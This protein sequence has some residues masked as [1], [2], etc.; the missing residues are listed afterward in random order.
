LK[1][2]WKSVLT[3]VAMLA[4]A[5]P[6]FA[7]DYPLPKK[8]GESFSICTGCKSLNSASEPN[9]G[10]PTWQFD[11]PL[12]AFAGRVV[13]SQGTQNIQHQGHR[14]LRAGLVRTAYTA[15]GSAPPRVYAYIGLGTFGA[16]TL[17]TFATTLKNPMTTVVTVNGGGVGLRNGKPEKVAKPD[18]MVYPEAP[19]SG[20]QVPFVD[21]T[22]RLKDFDFDD[23]GYVY[24]A[25][26]IFGWGIVKDSGETGIATLPLV[27][28]SQQV[29]DM[30]PDRIISIKSNNK[31]YVATSWSSKS[32]LGRRIYDVTDPKAPD[33]VSQTSGT[34]AQP[35]V[36]KQWSKDDNA[37]VVAVI[38]GDEVLR[39]YDY[40]AYVRNSAPM[41][42]FEGDNDY[43]SLSFDDKGVLW[44]I[45]AAGNPN[46]PTKVHKFTPSNNG[47]SEAILTPFPEWFDPVKIHARNGYLAAVGR[48]K[49]GP[50][51]RIN[52]FVF[53]TDGNGLTHLDTGDFFLKYYHAAPSGFAQPEGYT[54][55]PQDIHILKMGTK[56]Y[57]MYMVYGLGDVFQLEGSGP[58]LSTAIRGTTFGTPNPNSKGTAAGPFPGDPVTF[59]TTIS[60]ATGTLHNI[61]WNFGNPED[62]A[63]N[64]KSGGTGVDI[65]H[66]FTGLSTLAK[67]TTPKTVTA[68]LASDSSV[69]DATT[70]S[71]AVPTPR[72]AL[73]ATDE[74]LTEAGFAV[75]PNDKFVDASDGSIEGHFASW[76]I[77]N[78]TTK[79]RPDQSIPVGTLGDHT[80]ELTASYG[81]YDEDNFSTTGSPF[82]VKV[83]SL[84]YDVLPFLARFKP[85]S[86][87]GSTVTY[88]ATGRAT[89]D[90]AILTA[91]EWTFKWTLTSKSGTEKETLTGTANIPSIPNFSFDKSDLANEDVVK[92]ELNVLPAGLPGADQF[93]TFAIQ[94]EVAL[95][96]P[97][98]ELT[99][100]GFVND[101]CSIKAVSQ[102]GK[103]TAGWNLSWSVKQGT[104]NVKSGSGNPLETF[105]LSIEGTHTVSVT[106]TVFDTTPVTKNFTVE[107]SQCGPPPNVAQ[108]AIDHNCNNC[109]PGDEITLRA[110][111][112]HY[113][114][115]ECDQFLWNFDD[116]TT[117]SGATVKHTFTSNKTYNVKLTI[118]NPTNTTGITISEQVKVGSGSPPPPPPPTC[119]APANID[120]SWSGSGCSSGGSACKAGQNITFQGRRGT[121]SLQNCDSAAWTFDGA[122]SN[123]KTPTR[124]FTAGNHTVTLKVT[125]EKGSSDTVTKTVVI[126]PNTGGGNCSGSATI[127][128]VS[129]GFRGQTSGCTRTNG[130]ICQ[131]NETIDFTT[132]FFN[133]TQQACDR[134][135]FTFDDGTNALGGSNAAIART[136]TGTK[137][138][139]NVSV[140]VYNSTNTNGVTVS[141]LVPFSN[142]PV[143]LP[144]VLT[145]DFPTDGVKGVPMTFTV[146]ADRQATGWRWEFDG[147]P[148][149]S[150]QNEVGLSSTITHTFTTAGRKSVR[151]FAR[152]AAD[153]SGNAPTSNKLV[154]VDIEEP[155]EARYLLP[156]VGHAPGL[157]GSNWRTDVQFF[158]PIIGPNNP[159]VM[160]ATFNGTTKELRVADSTFIYS[161]FMTFFTSD[162]AIGPVI[163]SA[164]ADKA[165]QIWTRTY[166]QSE[167][168]TF[169]QF[170][171]AIRLDEA[172]GGAAV[173]SGMYYL[174]G[175]RH[176][177]RYR[178]NI[179]FVN[180]NAQTINATVRV[181]DESRTAI[182]QFAKTLPPLQYMQ[183]TLA[184]EVALP[185][186]RAFY[187]EIEVP[188][189]QWVIAYASYIDSLSNDPLY[190]Q[191]VREN[192][193]SSD[194]FRSIVVPGVGHTGQWRSDVTIF[195]PDREAMNFDLIYY[196]GAG[197]K[198]GEAKSIVLKSRESLQ[199]NDIIKQGVFGAEVPDGAGILEIKT[200]QSPIPNTRFPLAFSRTYF[201]Q[202]G[203]GTYGQA[204]AGV[205]KSRA[206]V[207][208]NK[209]A[210]IPGVR[211]DENYY[212]NVGV[213]NLSD[214]P[215]VVTIK[216]LNPQTGDVAAMIQDIV[217]PNAS[218]IGGFDFG[219]LTQGTIQVETNGGNLWAFASVIDR[220][221][222]DPEYVAASPR[223]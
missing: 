83:A 52:G 174:A 26:D 206:N 163:I 88:G 56:V 127:A 78:N 108:M 212:T 45:E 94:T 69:S 192:E 4:V 166:N 130:I 27:Q 221:T 90:T 167:N 111:P 150:K 62:T 132:S 196:D 19:R 139:Y 201:D 112:F 73:E 2:V 164:P 67:V 207:K 162:N 7:Q 213:T 114:I 193:L 180:P 145:T 17:D 184:N 68:T 138:A 6:S 158:N 135:D 93:A 43:V 101:L 32:L 131:R 12:S 64:T 91:T 147:V 13:D 186:D 49:R 86:R 55:S 36:I 66:Q 191:A 51:S 136:L 107:A 98:I 168:G 125:N 153:T 37:R 152:N 21:S 77:D 176:D 187:L 87:S 3:L 181:Y 57:L 160:Q 214:A 143:I 40:D 5:A 175:L 41:E 65:T 171:P 223:Q 113:V 53:K 190:L 48:V 58:S 80:V 10:K 144:P 222:K 209:P 122:G 109:A 50:N 188:E 172:G 157:A 106:E 33:L 182:A 211:S 23:R 84:S 118:K 47:Y 35:T 105:K 189:G 146:T 31:Y 89:N 8:A 34:N 82:T 85:V 95:P 141:V 121:N 1:F 103:S 156:I 39:I 54:S 81:K 183:F 24:L 75:L 110:V 148:D 116:G 119:T 18:A 217:Q 38:G 42:T 128:N 199:Y 29:N 22:E 133:Y 149:L 99:N 104:T 210:I 60:N 161:D 70:V 177:D 198:R 159:L 25:Y 165:P 63:G 100:C 219:F 120:F 20:W 46:S 72:I 220:R 123:D 97:V 202:P 195:N 154:S 14:T 28:G 204:I 215:A 216:L 96:D 79:L 16:Y 74:L 92:L 208:L 117:G 169:G 134:F 102:S 71:L 126:E 170:I 155:T 115:Q 140:K 173:G 59:R 185:N 178:T 124:T 203:Q 44:A 197:V 9:D 61:G 205:A 200:L 151:V 194:D 11:D 15:R 30:Q 218:R 129:F 142:V 179:G 137:N 76:K